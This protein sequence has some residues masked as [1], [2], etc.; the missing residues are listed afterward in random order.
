M[1]RIWI[2]IGNVA[3]TLYVNEVPGEFLYRLGESPHHTLIGAL[4]LGEAVLKRAIGLTA[5]LLAST[6]ASRADQHVRAAG[7]ERVEHRVVRG[8]HCTA[9]LGLWWS[10]SSGTCS[11]GRQM[12]RDSQQLKRV[13]QP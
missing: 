7:G 10:S 5:R 8:A 4:V 12:L 2:V 1:V 3:M 9:Q 13:Q 6:G 11:T